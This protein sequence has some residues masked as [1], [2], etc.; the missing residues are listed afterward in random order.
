AV[1]VARHG[2]QRRG[3]QRH[4]TTFLHGGYPRRRWAEGIAHTGYDNHSSE[5]DYGQ[6]PE[7][8]R[9]C[10]KRASICETWQICIESAGFA[11]VRTCA[12]DAETMMPKLARCRCTTDSRVRSGLAR[13]P[14]LTC[15]PAAGKEVDMRIKNA[16]LASL[17][18][19]IW[20]SL[21]L[22][23]APNGSG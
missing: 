2:V 13:F 8:K 19:V 14:G 9:T 11:Q 4:I 10:T 3:T 15:R 16:L 5:I 12:D 1:T 22:G 17:G 23:Q 18:T 20:S 21:A 6:L 7:K